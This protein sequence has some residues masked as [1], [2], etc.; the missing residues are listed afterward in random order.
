[1]PPIVFTTY[2]RIVLAHPARVLA[3]MLVVLAFFAWQARHFEP[4][5]VG[6]RSAA[7]GGSRPSDLSSVAG[8][9]RFEG[10]CSSSPS[11]RT[12]TSSTNRPSRRFASCATGCAR[13]PASNR[14]PASSTSPLLENVEGITL[15]GIADHI[16][17]LDDPGTDRARA[18]QEL[19]ASPVFGEVVVEPRCADGRDPA[20]DAGRRG[21]PGV[22]RS[23]E[24]AVDEADHGGSRRRRAR[25]ARTH[26]AVLRRGEAPRR[27]Q[28]ARRDRGDPPRARGVRRCRHAASRRRADDHRAT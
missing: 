26:R 6:R 13:S 15:A 11:H 2:E 1:M 10:F 16:R 12:P 24:P 18:R 9:L 19:L 21:V 25:R 20:H 28:P 8:A 7:R 22:A 14:S 4:R 3:V 27:R 5:R 17:T 23:A